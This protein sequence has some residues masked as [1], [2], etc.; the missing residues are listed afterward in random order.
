VNSA[1]GST[2]PEDPRPAVERAHP[3]AAPLDLALAGVYE[4]RRCELYGYLLHLTHEPQAAEDLLQDTFVRLIGEARAGRMPRDVRPW[5]YRVATNEAIDRGRRGVRLARLLPRLW[6][7]AEP[8]PPEH[9]A[10]RAERD[11]DVRAAL[12]HLDAHAR[13]ALLLAGQGFDGHEIAAMVG[14]SESATRTMMCRARIQL[15]TL[16]EAGEAGS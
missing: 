15:R 12:A 7:R 13:A 2:A 1:Y 8:E 10:L 11:A 9:Q 5:L 3:A 16:V 4:E 6:D 14:R